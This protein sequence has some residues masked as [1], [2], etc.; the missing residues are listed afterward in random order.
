MRQTKE[1]V[2]VLRYM[3]YSCFRVHDDRE[4]C[5]S[6]YSVLVVGGHVY[7][8]N[9]IGFHYMVLYG[10]HIILYYMGSVGYKSG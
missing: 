1:L 8:K 2:L 3:H 5:C 10:F 4:N 6:V 7:L 9:R